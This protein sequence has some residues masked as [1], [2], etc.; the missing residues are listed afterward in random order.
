MR[1]RDVCHN[2]TLGALKLANPAISSAVQTGQVL[3][4][5]LKMGETSASQAVS[6]QDPALKKVAFHSKI[7]G[8]R[9]PR[10][11]TVKRGDTLNAVAR[12]FDVELSELKSW[13]PQLDHS[14]GIQAGKRIVVGLK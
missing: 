5:P 8:K 1:V 7:R 2:T 13:N 10:Y 11:Y 4:L 3:S 9:Q 12:H 6:A 14:H